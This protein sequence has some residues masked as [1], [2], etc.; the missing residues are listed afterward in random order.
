MKF[1]ILDAMKYPNDMQSLC[2]IEV[3]DLIVQD[4]FAEESIEC[5]LKLCA[6]ADLEEIYDE[7]S[8]EEIFSASSSEQINLDSNKMLPSS[9]QASKLELKDLADHLKY[10]YL[11]EEKTLLVINT[12]GFPKNKD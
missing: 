9:V 11:G 3:I 2:Q 5:E 6:Q 8:L 10:V 1:N 4:V 12:K 7:T